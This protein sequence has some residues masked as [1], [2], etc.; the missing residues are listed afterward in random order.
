MPVRALLV[1]DSRHL[2]AVMRD[3]L[4]T[5]GGFAIAGELETEAEAGLWLDEHPDGCDL[6]VVD[7]ILAEG[8][9]MGVVAKCRQAAP[10]ARIV[11]FSDYATP[12]IRNHCLRLGADQVFPKSEDVNA[13]T[14][15]CAALA[16]GQAPPPMVAQ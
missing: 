9:G 2:R 4:H 14:D 15:Y 5:I 10:S 11:V 16:A 12:G 3:L 13:L 8:T 7:L 6:A 1:E